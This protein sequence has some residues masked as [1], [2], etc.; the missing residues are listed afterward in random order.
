MEEHI[1][2][3]Q[4]LVAQS[5]DRLKQA[6]KQYKNSL[7]KLEQQRAAVE[8]TKKHIE[9]TRLKIANRLCTLQDLKAK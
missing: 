5:A 1:K 7:K 6:E 2:R 8:A 3:L 4:E 9:F